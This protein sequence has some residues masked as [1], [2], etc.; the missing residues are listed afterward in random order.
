MVWQW[1]CSTKDTRNDELNNLHTPLLSCI[2][3]DKLG[4]YFLS[5]PSCIFGS[6]QRSLP[7]LKLTREKKAHSLSLEP[8]SSNLTIAWRH[9]GLLPFSSYFFFQSSFVL[10]VPQR[11][12]NS[13]P[14]PTK[15]NYPIQ[16][17]LV[18]KRKFC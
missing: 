9:T 3:C 6:M 2:S 7:Q 10:T 18:A 12:L 16:N 17:L 5:S 11:M 15:W 8:T 4:G 14:L 1:T 13:C